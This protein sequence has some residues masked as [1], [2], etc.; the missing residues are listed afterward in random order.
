MW[1]GNSQSNKK[2]ET[3]FDQYNKAILYI[4]KLEYS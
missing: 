2:N 4:D 3:W 1:Y